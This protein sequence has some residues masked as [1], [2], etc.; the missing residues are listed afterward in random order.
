MHSRVFT[1]H[2][3]AMN[4]IRTHRLLLKMYK[5]KYF[6][7]P[8]KRF[9]SRWKQL[10]RIYTWTHLWPTFYRYV[11]SSIRAIY[12]IDLKNV[13][14]KGLSLFYFLLFWLSFSACILCCF[15]EILTTSSIIM[16]FFFSFYFSF[17]VPTI[18]PWLFWL[19]YN[20][21][22]RIHTLLLRNKENIDSK[23]KKK[24]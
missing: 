7:F 2:I 5:L 9:G 8:F 17:L 23:R 16:M 24:L 12:S 19:V 22:L 10:K 18:G 15:R 13:V 14:S 4:T 1:L 3:Q 11:F 21:Y 20:L 6:L